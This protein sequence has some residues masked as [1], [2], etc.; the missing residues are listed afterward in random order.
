MSSRRHVALL[1]ALFTLMVISLGATACTGNK[2]IAVGGGPFDD[3]TAQP[4]TTKADVPEDTGP[5][6][7]QDTHTGNTLN[8]EIIPLED[9]SHPIPVTITKQV[10]IRAKVIDYNLGGPASGVLVQYAI[11]DKSDPSGDAN[12]TATQAQ[13]DDKG[14]VGVTFRANFKSGVTYTV[15]LSANGADPVTLQLK[16]TDKPKGSIKVQIMP[17]GP[18]NIKNA[19]VRLFPGDYTCGL[20]NPVNIP[21]NVI[22]DK[23]LL[24]A[25]GNERDVQWDDLP[26]GSRYTIVATAESPDGHLAAAGCVDGVIVIANQTN[27]VSLKLYMLSLNPAGIYDA[28]NVFDFTNAIPG[29]LGDLAR[30]ITLLFND[31][32]KFII[33]QI[34]QLV[35]NWIPKWVTDAAFSLFE[36]QLSSIITDWLLHNSPS[37]VQ[38][39]FTI[40]Q[41]LTQVVNHLEM[42]ATLKISK[43]SSDYY[44][45]GV[46]DWTGI[47]LYWHYGCPKQGDPGYD[48]NCGRF[49]FSITAFQ[50]TEFPMDIIEGRFTGSIL[51]FNQFDMDN[52]VIKINY[53]KLIVFVL[54][55]M[56]LPAISGQHN[57]TDAI[58][59]FIN[60]HSIAQA[61]SNPIL[62][63]IGV[64]EQDLENFCTNSITFVVS[65]VEQVLGGLALDSQLRLQGHATLND[66]D[67]DLRVDRITDGVYTGH[68]E[69][70]G[71]EGNAFSGTWHAERH[72]AQ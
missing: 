62:D 56:I 10:L 15:K 67:D 29:Q 18:I 24:G 3:T 30:Q 11:V 61:F 71:Q 2:T 19:D 12:L 54:D 58:L 48:P 7:E 16:V 20:F 41:D 46:E 38:D 53:G 32:G 55:E 22:S 34:K 6:Q 1:R 23:P 42:Q 25:I 45:Q 5:G 59:S 65:P 37:W 60:C 26:E 21:D 43:L 8:R 40:G 69:S 52:H 72:Q 31:P 28:T 39:I 47:V 49:V 13:T 36:D 64:S 44:V 66:D 51:N 9:I 27:V 50:N 14:E 70:G 17:Q 68:V 35:Y 63:G 4:D 57:L 33:E